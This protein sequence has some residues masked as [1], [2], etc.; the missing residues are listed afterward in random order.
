MVMI[1]LRHS[2]NQVFIP[3]EGVSIT[4][5]VCLPLFRCQF[6]RYSGVIC[7]NLCAT[8]VKSASIYALPSKLMKRL[9]VLYGRY[10]LLNAFFQSVSK[11]AVL[12]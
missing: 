8:Q 9:D 1:G 7:A 4:R 11:T 5:L 3:K 6:M 12:T 10:S 2:M